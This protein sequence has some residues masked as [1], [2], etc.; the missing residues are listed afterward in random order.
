MSLCL[1]SAAVATLVLALRSKPAKAYDPE[2]AKP[3]VVLAAFGTCVPEALRSI[4]NVESRVKAAFPDYD[5]HLAFT[6]NMI[7]KAWRK[8][9]KEAGQSSSDPV[10]ARYANVKNPLSV[11]AEIQETGAGTVL[12]QSLHMTDGEEYQ[13]LA[14]QIEALAKIEALQASLRPFQELRLGAP[15]LGLGDGDKARLDR[16]AFAWRPW[17]AAAADSAAALV[18]MGHGN[19]RMRQE[20]FEKFETRLRRDY[21]RIYLGTVEAKPGGEEVAE[22]VARDKPPSGKVILA[23]LMVVAGDHAVNDMAGDEPGSWKLLFA[24][25]GFEV[26]TWLTGLGSLDSWADIYVESLRE[27]AAR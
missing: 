1:I 2:P 9:W 12:V 11:L 25:K 10:A 21:Q 16:A 23:P 3:A 19:E 7:R 4:E 5:V 27:L 18:L 15:A 17:V 20:V 14:R 13:N 8:K 22:M 24:E 6:S 26:T